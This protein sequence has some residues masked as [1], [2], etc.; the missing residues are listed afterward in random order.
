M[1]ARN[2]AHIDR[3]INDVE[4]EYEDEVINAHTR[5]TRTLHEIE[6]PSELPRFKDVCRLKEYLDEMLSQFNDKPIKDF[7]YSQY[8]E[9]CKYYIA[10]VEMYNL[11]RINE[12]AS[13]S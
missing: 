4:M 13:I 11:R 12:V 5:K 6:E 9:Y 1:F 10:R 7:T 3:L 2:V 8:L